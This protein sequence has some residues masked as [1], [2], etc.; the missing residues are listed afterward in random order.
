MS[1]P[2]R[3]LDEVL[4]V[5]HLLGGKAHYDD[6]YRAIYDR[7][8]MNLE[9]N[10]NWKAAVRQTIEK[11]SID[12]EAFCGKANIFYSVEG[13]G[14]GTWGIREPFRR[15]I[16]DGIPI[17]VLQ[18][19]YAID[20]E[21]LKELSDQQLKS[22][23]KSHQTDTP[24]KRKASIKTYDRNPYVSEY[25]KRKARGYCQ[26][27]NQAAP[28]RDKDNTPYLETHHIIWLSQGGGDTI[29]NTVALCPNCHRKMHIVNGKEDVE[30]LRS[31]TQED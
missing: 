17:E 4:D 3:W 30:T 14:S 13:K 5:I 9:V 19:K 27:C 28:F 29:D 1:Q 15:K 26:L 21:G 2:R 6:I 10:K 24:M 25:A 23:A 31:L 7:K 11:Y 12:S 22:K 18:K 20:R 16:D 8:I